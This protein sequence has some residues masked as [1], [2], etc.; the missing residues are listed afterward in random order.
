M[1]LQLPT[2]SLE[3]PKPL[4]THP[5]QRAKQVILANRA[6]QFQACVRTGESN[7]HD[8]RL[9]GTHRDRHKSGGRR[10]SDEGDR[11]PQAGSQPK[12]MA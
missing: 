12:K 11:S 3:R 2:Q 4:E 5:F 6:E 10:L 8:C 9:S 7:G 1:E